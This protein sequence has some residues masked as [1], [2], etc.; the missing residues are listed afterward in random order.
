MVS[1]LVWNSPKATALCVLRGAQGQELLL[2]GILGINPS[3]ETDLTH[4]D[5]H[6]SGS[7]RDLETVQGG[8]IISQGAAN[9][10]GAQKGQILPFYLNTASGLQYYGNVTLV[11][12]IND[13]G[14]SGLTDLDGKSLLPFRIDARGNYVTAGAAE[15]LILHWSQALQIQDTAISRI[16]LQMEAQGNLEPFARSIVTQKDYNVWI[17]VGGVVTWYHFGEYLEMGGVT[18]LV[19][20]FIVLLNLGLVMISIV[21]ERT[22]EIFTLTCIGFN[23]TH[24]AAIFLAESVVMGLVGGGLGYLLGMSAYRL[25]TFLS[26]D[27]AVRQKLEW[28]WS[29]IGVLLSLGAAVLSAIRP[30]SRAAMKVTPSLVKKVKLETEKEKVRREEDIWKVYQAQK[31]AMPVRIHEEMLF[32]SSYFS[33]RM[34]GMK[35]GLFEK[36]KDYSE[37]EE[38]TPEGDQIRHF[39]FTYTFLESGV[40]LVTVNELL[41][42]KRSKDDYYSLSLESKPKTPGLPGTFVD[43]TIRLVRDILGDWEEERPKIMGKV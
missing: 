3:P 35:R 9:Q 20:L 28:Y 36:V 30:A 29:A 23:P 27:I 32:F 37:A 12:V 10:L 17:A 4:M 7:L 25:M 16:A 24:I 5:R 2:N 40:E 43:R 33:T 13:G 14:L 31:I 21:S 1:S 41:A 39:L 26:V 19:P 6:V 15:V 34:E 18:L 22:R 11:G 38:E 8:V 42:R